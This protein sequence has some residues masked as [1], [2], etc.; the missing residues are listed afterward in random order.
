M[1]A[2]KQKVVKHGRQLFSRLLISCQS[3]EC[4]LYD[5]FRHENHPFSAALSDGGKLHACQ[6]ASVL[7]SHVP[8][9]DNA[10]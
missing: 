5:F 8:L 7:E 6:L 3:R 4:D 1:G 9:P 2:K 10:L